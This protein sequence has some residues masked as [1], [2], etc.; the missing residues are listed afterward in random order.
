MTFDSSGIIITLAILFV[1]VGVVS[2]LIY[3]FARYYFKTD[4]NDKELLTKKPLEYGVHDPRLEE[5]QKKLE[6]KSKVSPT[7]VHTPTQTMNRALENTRSS[8][9]ARMKSALTGKTSISTELKSELEEILFTNDL[10]P[11][12]A[13]LLMTAA[14][15]SLSQSEVSVENLRQKLKSEMLAIFKTSQ[16]QR[17]T[18]LFSTI[19]SGVKPQVLMITGVNGVGKTTTIG[20]LASYASQMGLKTMIVAGDTFRAA[21]D[22]QL[23]VWAERAKVEYFSAPQ[24][25]DPSAVAYSALEKAK[26]ENYDLIIVDTAGRLHTQAHLMEELK[27]MERVMKKVIP[28]APHE[29]LIVLDANS[30]Q[31][32]LIQARE[33]HQTLQLTGCVITKLDGSAKGGV[34][35]GISQE[36]KLPVCF[37][38]IG[39]KVEDLRPFQAEEFVEALI[40]E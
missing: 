31:N 11:Q 19:K 13:E 39:E 21:A 40:H 7:Q 12:T 10:G 27:K 20:K 14:V 16:S 17:T 6:D 24:T 25:K 15:Q 1:V 26:S 28:D 22:E 35:V 2:S 37:V 36:L 30:G 9:W 3:Y 32:A 29:K 4:T 5:I 33:F 23:K 38:G 8:F 34:L 18:D